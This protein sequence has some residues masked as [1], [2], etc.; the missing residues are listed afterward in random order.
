[1]GTA[2]I[3]EDDDDIR[4]LLEVVLGQ[5]GYE[6]S[7]AA[8]GREGIA[9][10]TDAPPDLALVDVGLPDMEGYEVVRRARTAVSGTIVL[11]SARSQARDAQLGLEAGADEY[12]TKPFRPL[13]LR[14]D[15]RR[16]VARGVTDDG[17]EPS[18]S[19]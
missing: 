16:V 12:L 5:E 1:M 19:A 2:T 4:R 10:L 15:L 9:L 13:R 8:T 6:V 17:Q 14:E 18:A 3:I 7:S 11:L